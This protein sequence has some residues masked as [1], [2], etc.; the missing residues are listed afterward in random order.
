MST[1]TYMISLKS[2]EPIKAAIGSQDQKLLNA[3]LSGFDDDEDMESYAKNMIMNSPP[4]KE[5]GCWN[6]LVEPLANHLGLSPN[7]LPMDDWKHYHVWEDYRPNINTL[8]SPAA[9]KFLLFLEQGRPFIGSE[10]EHDGC[11]FAWLSTDEAEL[12]LGE[13]AKIDA[14]DFG[15][16]AEFH[17]EL[18]ESLQATVDNKCALFLGAC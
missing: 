1:R 10:I 8:V 13:L 16:L 2:I 4:S 12:L 6:Y 7:Y 9:Q 11:M 5:P 14:D 3:L 18:L 15:E 17:E